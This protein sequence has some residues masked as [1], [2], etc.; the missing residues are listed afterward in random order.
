MDSTPGRLNQSRL[1][2]HV[3]PDYSLDDALK[4]AALIIRFM[5]IVIES[6]T[7]PNFKK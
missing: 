2:T 6:T 1:F 3:I 7:S 4:F 5:P